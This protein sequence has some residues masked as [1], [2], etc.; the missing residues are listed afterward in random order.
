MAASTSWT[1]SA[2]SI[3]EPAA[4]AS[5]KPSPRASTPPDW[6]RRTTGRAVLRGYEADPPS[7][8]PRWRSTERTSRPGVAAHERYRADTTVRQ[9]INVMR[10][11]I[12]CLSSMLSLSS[13]IEV[14]T[15]PRRNANV[16]EIAQAGRNAVGV[17]E[18]AE[19]PDGLLE[20]LLRAALVAFEQQV[21]GKIGN[22]D[23]PRHALSPVSRASASASVDRRSARS[24]SPARRHTPARGA[25]WARICQRVSPLT[26]SASTTSSTLSIRSSSPRAP[27][28]AWLRKDCAPA[29]R[30]KHRLR[31][32]TPART[33]E[34]L[35]RS[36]PR[37]SQ[38]RQIDPANINA[39]SPS[40]VSQ[41]CSRRLADVVLLRAE[42]A[43]PLGLL[44]AR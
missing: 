29:R 10:S 6:Y 27:L 11:P 19:E 17:A 44:G 38:N 43:V 25:S 1:A 21:V 33:N 32:R 34:L 26:R 37:L 41:A 40:A 20:S 30:A 2:S 7:R 18:L 42:P 5:A 36:W 4:N 35:H 13:A 24:L 9:W 14:S 28:C 23:R 39:R 15:S 12:E 16:R 22:G 31:L 8:E 3:S